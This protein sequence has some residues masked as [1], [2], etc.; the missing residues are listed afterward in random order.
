M[1]TRIEKELLI[2]NED[3]FANLCRLYL[4]FQ[5]NIVHSS[6]FALGKEKSKAGIPD[7]FIAVK[8]FYIFNEITTQE[9]GLV[10]KLKKDISDCFNQN[11]IPNDKILKIILICNS[12]ISP[13]I[14]KELKEYKN[15]IDSTTELEIIG[16]D[17][18]AN[19]IVNEFPSISRELGVPIDTGQI[20]EVKTFIKQTEDSKFSTTLK[21]HFFNRTED[22]KFGLDYLKNNNILLI[23]GQAGVGKTKLSLELVE[24]FKT[25]NTDYLLKYI[26]NNGNLDIWE[27]LKSQ[28]LKNKKYLIVIDDA[29]KLRN[30]LG[31]ILNYINQSEN[32]NVKV[33]LTVRNYVRKD[34]EAILDTFEVIELKNFSNAE[35]SNILQS[36]DF[37]ISEYY[38]DKIFSI[39]KG[40]PRIAIMGAL[41]GLKNDLDKL[42]NAS[43]IHEEYFS[44][45]NQNIKSLQDEDLLKVAGILSLF[46]VI[47]TK[48]IEF[49]KEIESYFSISKSLLVSKL[50]LLNQS[51]V[52][53]EFKGIYKISDQILG[54]YIFYIVFIKEKFFSFQIL[55]D[56]YLNKYNFPLI[57]MLTPII[58]NYG[59]ESVKNLI[60]KDIKEKWEIVEN[61]EPKAIKYLKDFWY[62]LSSETL[63]F[64]N[65]KFQKL[66]PIEFDVL[67]F[68]ITKENY[69]EQY[70]DNYIT[71]LI[72]FKEIPEKFNFALELLFKYCLS[73]QLL[74]SKLLKLLKQSFSYSQYSKEN[75][76]NIQIM[77]FDFLYSRIEINRV[78]YTKLILFISDSF[79]IDSYEYNKS[80]GNTIRI[81]PTALNISENQI[82]FRGKLWGFI[83]NCYE[84]EFLKKSVLDFFLKH[85]YSYHFNVNELIEFDKNYIIPFFESKFSDSNF[86]ESIIV[87]DYL[88]R[89]KRLNINY[90]IGLENK[91]LCKEYNTWLL[92]NERGEDNKDL[93][94]KTYKEYEFRNYIELL[95]ELEIIQ[96]H[97]PTYFSGWSVILDSITTIFEELSKKDFNLL[98]KVLEV[99]FTKELSQKIRLGRV[100]KL[101]DYT[102]NN[103]SELRNLIINK[104]NNNFLLGLFLNIPSKLITKNDYELVIDFLKKD[105]VNH[106]YFLEELLPKLNHLS[107]NVEKIIDDIIKIL[108]EKSL[109]SN[110]IYVSPD[111]FKYLNE[112]QIIW[113]ESNLSLI[114]TLYLNLDKKNRSFDY[115]LEVLLII[116]DKDISFMAELL[117]FNFDNKSYVSKNDILENNFSK[118]WNSLNYKQIFKTLLVFFS[119]YPVSFSNSPSEVSNV[120][121]GNNAKE[122]LLLMEIIKENE[123][124]KLIRKVFNIILA[125]YNNK[126]HKYLIEILNRNKG[127]DFF[128]RLDLYSQSIVYSGSRI[129]RIRQKIEIYIE[130]KDLLIRLNDIS[131]LEHIDYLE[132]NIIYGKVS[133]ENER[134][135]EFIDRWGL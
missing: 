15:K 46:K 29:N 70:D 34:V 87:S 74:F 101:I 12:K 1:I 132:S 4:A 37:N 53:D 77:L 125:K 42:N 11:S 33:I 99:L 108:I 119:R 82:D 95:D 130:I 124:E 94:I 57:N 117:H 85:K 135:R 62:Y 84:D 51:E 83:F 35:L 72:N 134:K 93:I 18:F 112:N 21:N 25:E 14:D 88:S 76:Y 122:E 63:I 92:L 36:Q 131:F 3:K 103:I 100:F 126:K 113:F 31:L 89:I 38:V 28:I 50:N 44:S 120:F 16:I 20:L 64:L 19:I 106:I 17:A 97:K 48:Q 32:N 58:N 23:T 107:L 133:I 81:V 104:N 75:K 66:K 7:N 80:N 123:D 116:L 67:V 41:A 91:F 30:N 49:I 52:A 39:S 96:K 110:Y 26:V 69:I 79:L 6:G 2:C 5:Y 129:P 56:A 8:D 102:N 54:E 98:I 71:L 27:D 55:L 78:F 111:F 90:P 40:N 24:N 45:V 127:I 114:K 60:I 128:R 13:K 22:L 68:E 105:N 115:N 10:G 118:L 121:K 109:N 65:R 47:D 86:L 73:N 59:F 43:Q 9:K 61:D